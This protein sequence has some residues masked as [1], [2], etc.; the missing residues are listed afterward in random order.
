[1]IPFLAKLF[2]TGKP[3]LRIELADETS[4]ERYTPGMKLPP[5]ASAA[6][7]LPDAASRVIRERQEAGA[8][9]TTDAQEPVEIAPRRY[10]QE[11]HI[12]ADGVKLATITLEFDT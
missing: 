9:V 3:K 4:A 5:G 11:H 8:V 1:M 12:L 10:R 6:I 7:V 2:R